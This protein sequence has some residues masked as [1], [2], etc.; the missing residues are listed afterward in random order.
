MPNS[1]QD[2]WVAMMLKDREAEFTDYVPARICVGMAAI[3][4][5]YI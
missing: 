1:F 4:Q 3:L 2:E 5:N